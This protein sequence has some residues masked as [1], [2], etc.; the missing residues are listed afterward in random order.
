MK[1]VFISILLVLALASDRPKPVNISSINEV[2]GQHW[3]SG[4]LDLDDNTTHM[5]YFFFPS[6]NNQKTDPVLF[7]FNGGPGCS[8]LLGALYEHG[9]FLINDAFASLINNQFAW[10]K[11]ANVVYIESPANVGF[12]YMDT[13][14][15]TWND[16]MV[17][18]L[19]ARAIREF[20]E[21]WPEF[22]GRDTY[23]SGESYAGIYVPTA[24]YELHS[25]GEKTPLK[26]N[27]KGFAVGNGCTDPLECEFQNDYP[28]Y[29]MQL[30]RDIGYI[31]QTQY[32]TVESKCANQ[33]SNLPVE[34]TTVLDEVISIIP[35]LITLLMDS[36]SMMLTDHAM[37]TIKSK[38]EK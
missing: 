15:P 22:Q 3:F 28:V 36:T 9:P 8:S 38:A 37:K 13:K 7:W 2:Y 32:E 34:C 20:F 31:T 17:A 12:S 11:K 33:G 23:L 25:S 26:F 10:N 19:N 30:Y 35:R 1:V 27:L 5:H 14:A 16:D 4:Y 21:T 18:K 24:F 29:L 6:Q